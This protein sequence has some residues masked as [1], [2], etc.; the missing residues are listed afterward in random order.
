M[1]LG[2]EPYYRWNS[3]HYTRSC[4]H[5]NAMFEF[6]VICYEPGQSTSIHDYDSQTAWIHAVKGE[7]VEERIIY[8]RTRTPKELGIDLRQGKPDVLRE[9]SPFIGSSIKDP[10]RAITLNLYAKPLSKWRV[11]DPGTGASHYR[12]S[13]V[14]RHE[15]T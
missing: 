15:P 13:Q 7:V 1:L 14:P 9:G 5:R 3:K 10:E 6:L 11:Y 4:I 8:H 12:T 2:F